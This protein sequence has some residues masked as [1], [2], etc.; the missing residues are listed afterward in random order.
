LSPVIGPLI[1]ILI[2]C[3]GSILAHPTA[4]FAQ[5]S[6]APLALAAGA[7]AASVAADSVAAASVA[8]AGVAAVVG[9]QAAT[10][11]A[12]ITQ[13]NRTRLRILIFFSFGK[14]LLFDDNMPDVQAGHMIRIKL[15][16]AARVSELSSPPEV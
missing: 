10:I 2:V 9:V 13:T 11:I 3:P 4:S 15:N 7:A 5:T 6:G 12:N 8:A 16:A 1:P 14:E